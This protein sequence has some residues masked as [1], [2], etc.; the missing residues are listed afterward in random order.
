MEENNRD[1]GGQDDS[2]SC[3]DRIRQPKGY[4]FESQRKKIKAS[5]KGDDSSDGRERFRVSVGSTHTAGAHDFQNNRNGE[6][7]IMHLLT[8]F[9]LNNER[10]C[11]CTRKSNVNNFLRY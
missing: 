1:Q 11:P 3:P 8:E 10:I 2:D 9:C 5:E 6:I 7:S 4:R